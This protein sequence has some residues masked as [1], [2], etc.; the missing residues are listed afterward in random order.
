MRLLVG[1]LEDVD[2]GVFGHVDVPDAPHLLLAL[3]LPLEQLQLARD[4]PAVL[5]THT[6]THTHAHTDARTRTRTHTHTHTRLVK[7]PEREWN[8]SGV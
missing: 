5:R 4:V 1:P 3:R 7:G 8:S 2:E 6:R